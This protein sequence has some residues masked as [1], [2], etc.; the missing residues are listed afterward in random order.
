MDS[1]WERT[2][3]FVKPLIGNLEDKNPKD[4][5]GLTP[6]CILAANGH[7]DVFKYLMETVEDFSPKSNSGST[8]LHCAAKNG[9][10][11]ICKLIIKNV[12]N[13]HPVNINGNTP[14]DLAKNRLAN[15]R[16]DL[17]QLFE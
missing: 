6:L 5:S 1:K 3:L 7:L 4:N 15:D 9:H 10:L 8:P 11:D 17:I 14:K 16:P 13:K 12:Q 2:I